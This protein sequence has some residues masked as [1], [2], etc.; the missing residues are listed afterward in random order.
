[1]ARKRLGNPA[2]S[3]P[4]TSEPEMS[5]VTFFRLRLH[6]CSTLQDS[7][8]DSENFWNINSAPVNTPRY[9]K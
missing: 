9:S 6:S 2:L 8:S 5:G 4:T 3:E 7:C 1:M